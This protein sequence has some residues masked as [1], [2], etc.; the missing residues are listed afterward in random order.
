MAMPSDTRPSAPAPRPANVDQLAHQAEI[1]SHQA[2]EAIANKISAI[3]ASIHSGLTSRPP[4][5][6]GKL[7]DRL[8]E[9]I[10]QDTTLQ[11]VFT[12]A[13]LQQQYPGKTFDDLNPEQVRDLASTVALNIKC[14]AQTAPTPNFGANFI[15]GLQSNV[16]RAGQ[17]F[18]KVMGGMAAR[19]GM[20]RQQIQGMKD[21]NAANI[22]PNSPSGILFDL[23][24][25]G[26]GLTVMNF[27]TQAGA[28]AGGI[29]ASGQAPTA[30]EL[31]DEN[32]LVSQ[33]QLS[34]EMARENRLLEQAQLTD[35]TQLSANAT[36]TAQLTE[37]AALDDEMSSSAQSTPRPRPGQ[38]RE[39]LEDDVKKLAHGKHDVKKVKELAELPE[40]TEKMKDVLQGVR[41]GDFNKALS[42]ASGELKEAVSAL[43]SFAPSMR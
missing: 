6:H 9:T 21:F 4:A 19:N 22:N 10:A 31:A 43:K 41:S 39:E 18:D 30:T 32:E 5:L 36:L 42:A 11:N 3:V 13:A 16:N 40:H 14:I 2:S 38:A 15:Q 33:T 24:N 17:Y 26:D 20:R 37:E 23:Q 29:S 1:L 7:E 28:I 35:D 34:E 27:D 8:E 25:G 12:Q